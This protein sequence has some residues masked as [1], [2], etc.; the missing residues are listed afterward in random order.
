M[1]AIQLSDSIEQKL[2]DLSADGDVEDVLWKAVY[3]YE[4]SEHP[5]E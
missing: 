1:A 2:N 5:S 3:L 4:R